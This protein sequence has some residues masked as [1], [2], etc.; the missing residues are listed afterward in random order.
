[1]VEVIDFRGVV[2]V[3]EK[4]TRRSL[5]PIVEFCVRRWM[6]GGGEESVSEGTA[7]RP[8]LLKMLKLMLGGR[9]A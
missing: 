7:G 1:M 4:P 2:G 8:R 9:K 6:G 3:S 5:D